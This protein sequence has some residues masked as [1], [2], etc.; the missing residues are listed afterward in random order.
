V[1][2]VGD[3]GRVPLTNRGA[4]DDVEGRIDPGMIDLSDDD[5]DGPPAPAPAPRGLGLRGWARWSWRTLTSMRT[6]LLLLLILVLAAIPGSIFPQRVSDQF[7]VNQF[8]EENPTLAPILDRFGMFDVFGSPWFAAIYLLLFLSL[9]G[10]VIPRSAQLWR[11]WRDGPA[12]PPRRLPER[13]GAQRIAADDRTVA[14]AAARLQRDGWRVASGPDWVSAEKGFLREVGNLGFH[15]SMVAL[16]I[17]VAVG[18]VLGWR[19]N[20]VVREGQ[21]FANTLTQYDEW[22]GGAAVSPADLPPFAF[23]LESF[24]V[25]F[26]RGEAQ[27]GA[28]RDFEAVVALQRA[29]GAAATTETLRVNRPLRI[30]GADVYLIGHGY[31]PRVKVTAADGTTVFDDSVVFLPQDANFT[32]TGVIKLPDARPQLAFNAIFAPTATVDDEGPR[33]IFPAPDV[34]GLFLAAFTGDLGLD[35]GVPQNVYALDISELEQI[36]LEGLG[37]GQSWTL[38]G[39][40]TVEFVGVERYVSLKISHDPGRGWALLTAALVMVGLMLSLFVPRRRIWLR[41]TGDTAHIAGLARTER[42]APEEEVAGLAQALSRGPDGTGENRPIPLGE[43][44]PR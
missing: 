30:D 15:L 38:P 39:G 14:A 11:Q 13:S 33:S 20:V 37:P 3:N 35:T 27:R 32:S 10:C 23:T 41:R 31:A 19:G 17:A 43:G 7:G 4:I 12:E 40:A 42:A 21:G 8:F 18:S 26:E 29:P 22:S 16:L 24:S 25:D 44:A 5:T 1:I 36:G 34:P 9:V 6:A 2:T 28:P